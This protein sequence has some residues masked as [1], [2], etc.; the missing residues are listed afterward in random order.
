MVKSMRKRRDL[1]EGNI[2]KNIWY[3]AL[4]TMVTSALQDL[5]NI[6]D[7]IYVGKLGPSAIASVAMCGIVIGIANTVSIGIATGTVALVSRFFGA[8][9]YDTTD[10][11]VIQTIFLAVFSSIVIGIAGYFFS[12]PLMHLL[13]AKG[14]VLDL[15][16]IY[17][18]IMAVGSFTM[19]LS[20]SLNAI[21]RG[22]GDAITPM[23]V[24]IFSTMLNII[25]DPLLIFGIWFFPKMGVA[26]SSLATVIARGIGMFILLNIF[27][28]GHSYFHIKLNDFRLDIRMMWRIIKI[29]FFGSLQALLRNISALI[30]IRVVA[31]FGTFAVAAYGIGM[32]I[33][34]ATMM[35]GFGF[36]QASTVLVGQN[37]GAEKPKRAARSAWLTVG[38]YEI[39]MV[40]LSI[41]IFALAPFIVKAF[42][43]NPEVV[44]IG[45]QYIRIFSL[46]FVFLALS[47]VI[48]RSF[49]GAGDTVS[50]MVI[51][52][53]C[54][55]LFRIPFVILLAKLM[56][57]IGIWL[58]LA[59]SDV[60]QGITMSGWFLRGKWK[61]K[62]V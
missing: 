19:F 51:T 47:I 48:G 8:K 50:P 10:D 28:K 52:G 21:L 38:L 60:I 11:V 5:F 43:T 14:D 3:L 37:L 27:I 53:I 17:L 42:N 61:E 59:V 34:M 1:T 29:G 15:G 24:L 33:R 31:F 2:V 7:M 22:A 32:R 36:A 45:I 49:N 30:L 4:P 44:R 55:L 9:D 18:K 62:K 25:L 13:G 39:L 41:V 58:G 54:L 57:T 40:F 20:F 12:L 26:G 46:T 35:P 16:T 6:V 56:G 23:K